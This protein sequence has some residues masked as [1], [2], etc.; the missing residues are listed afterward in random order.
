MDWADLDIKMKPMWRILKE[1]ATGQT[2]QDVIK[3][4]VF[5][6]KY[7]TRF[8]R[9][10]GGSN[11]QAPGLYDWRVDLPRK[12]QVCMIDGWSSDNLYGHQQ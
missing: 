10:M 4:W 12:H 11:N 8:A 9:F 7:S 2:F 5:T 3:E 6:V 1:K